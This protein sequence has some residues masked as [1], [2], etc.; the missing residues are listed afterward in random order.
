M[1]NLGGA[2]QQIE[3][4]KLTVGSLS[5]EGKLISHGHSD[6]MIITL[7]GKEWHPLYR[8]CNQS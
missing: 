3:Q 4:I 5:A 8:V 2:L 7:D 6:T 1:K